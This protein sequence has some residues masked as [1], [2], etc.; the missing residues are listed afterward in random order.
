MVKIALDF[1]KER[2]KEDD[3]TDILNHSQLESLT[4]GKHSELLNNI[5]M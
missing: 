4:G 1:K 5:L 3:K 2:E